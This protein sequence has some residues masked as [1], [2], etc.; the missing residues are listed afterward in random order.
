MTFIRKIAEIFFVFS[1]P[2][3]TKTGYTER[4]EIF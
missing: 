3:P 2:F 4:K 1:I